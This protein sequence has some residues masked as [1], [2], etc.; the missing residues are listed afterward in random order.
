MSSQNN[1]STS[2]KTS[3]REFYE[4]WGGRENFMFSYGL[5]PWNA[6]DVREGRAI[7][8]VLKEN[9]EADFGGRDR[10]N[11]PQAQNKGSITPELEV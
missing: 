9:S 11:A 4:Q 3:N 6:D 8:K 5:K 2:N 7:T 10:D 1:K